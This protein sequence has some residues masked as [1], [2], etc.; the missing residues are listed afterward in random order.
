MDALDEAGIPYLDFGQDLIR[1][2]DDPVNKVFGPGAHFNARG[3]ALLAES[4]LAELHARALITIASDEAA[5]W[6]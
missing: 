5:A 1:N 2:S 4:V 6:K 3:D